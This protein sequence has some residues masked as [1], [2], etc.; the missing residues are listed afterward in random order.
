MEEN[1]KAS[2]LGEEL[3]G[4]GLLHNF[5]NSKTQMLKEDGCP[6][7]GAREKDPLFLSVLFESFS[8][9]RDVILDCTASTGTYVKILVCVHFFSLLETSL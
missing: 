3:N 4:E 7:R 8:K 2:N 5:T 6:W 1:R 9:P